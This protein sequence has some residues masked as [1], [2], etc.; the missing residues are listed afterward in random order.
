MRS[1]SCA[2]RTSAQCQNLPPPARHPAPISSHPPRPCPSPDKLTHFPSGNGV[3]RPPRGLE[4]P[5]LPPSVVRSGGGGSVYDGARRRLPA[6]HGRVTLPMWAAPL[7]VSTG[8]G[9]T[10]GWRPPS[11]G[12]YGLRRRGRC[13]TGTCPS[14]FRSSGTRTWERGRRSPGDSV[15][16]SLETVPLLST[17]AALLQL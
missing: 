13:W 2:A 4:G 1:R 8:R 14:R 16:S 7:R 12:C 5:R 11:G 6:L 15:F 3:A 17:A 10:L 9:Q